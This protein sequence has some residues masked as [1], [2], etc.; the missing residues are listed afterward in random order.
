M[1]V[2]ILG[3]AGALCALVSVIGIINGLFGTHIGIGTGGATTG[4]IPGDP[5][6]V[7]FFFII[8]ALCLLA[9]YFID[10]RQTRGSQVELNQQN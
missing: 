4:G 6:V 3:I 8:G 10:K 7:G 5:V 9:A 1:L 2:K